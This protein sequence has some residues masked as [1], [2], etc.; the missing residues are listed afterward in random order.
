M[1]F[2]LFRFTY[3]DGWAKHLTHLD[4]DVILI[5]THEVQ[6][7]GVCPSPVNLYYFIIY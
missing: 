7:F 5:A 6:E 2:G 3:Q 4:P 1:T